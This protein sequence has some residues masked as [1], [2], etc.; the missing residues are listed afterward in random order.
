MMNYDT[1]I[2][3]VVPVYKVEKYLNA[4]VESIVNQTYR[5]LEIILVDD[6]SPDNCPAM[7]DAWAK[8]DSRIRV[9]HKENSGAAS[10]KNAGL[11]AITGS[12]FS[13]VDGDDLLPSNAI[14]SLYKIL[15]ICN[16][17]IVEGSILRF[18]KTSPSEIATRSTS[19]Q[20]YNAEEALMQ[21]ML[22]RDF[23]QTPP[24]KLYHHSLAAI[25]FTPGTYIDD[26]F[27]TYRVFAQAQTLASCKTPVYYYRQHPESAI[28]RPYSLGRLDA[29]R[30]LDQRVAFMSAHFPNLVPLAI[31]TFASCCIYH[32]QKL[33][34]YPQLDPDRQHRQWILD[35]MRKNI[36]VS[37]FESMSFKERTRFILFQK[38]PYLFCEIRNL[39]KRGI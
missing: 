5:N 31:S 36:A 21:L 4:C 18:W 13:F 29:V 23:H 2:S 33:C 27:W 14:L 12:F 8:R 6:G 22:Q 26:E 39:F 24:G 15:E 28:N 19:S 25:R 1:L 37:A 7:C 35:L 38:S 9:I 10:A 3:V 30:A 34:L 11:E 20:I 32:F 16:C 17:Q